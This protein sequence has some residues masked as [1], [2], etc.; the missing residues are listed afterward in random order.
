VQMQGKEGRRKEELRARGSG[1]CRMRVHRRDCAVSRSV[2][3]WPCI[4]LVDSCAR[5]PLQQPRGVARN[6]E[7]VKS[8]WSLGGVLES[9]CSFIVIATA[10]VGQPAPHPRA[11]CPVVEWKEREKAA[12]A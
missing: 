8:S 6:V 1:S 12:A 11:P 10:I 5:A 2:A 7:V 3:R 9:I 4:P